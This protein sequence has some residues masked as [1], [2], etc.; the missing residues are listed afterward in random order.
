MSTEVAS[1][2]TP[3]LKY[4]VHDYG[5]EHSMFEGWCVCD[6]ILPTT[7]VHMEL[8]ATPERNHDVKSAENRMMFLRF[9]LHFPPLA[10]S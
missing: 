6:W 1:S 7:L 3:H 10:F 4:D 8:Q 5:S 9:C 2:S